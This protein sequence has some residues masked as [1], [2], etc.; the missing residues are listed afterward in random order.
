MHDQTNVRGNKIFTIGGECDVRVICGEAYQHYPNLA[1]VGTITEATA[2]AVAA[3]SAGL[4]DAPP[5]LPPPMS[6]GK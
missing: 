5:P 6:H 4:E 2:A 3:S 1:L